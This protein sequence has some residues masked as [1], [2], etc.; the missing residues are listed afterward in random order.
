MERKAGGRRG[1][2]EGVWR[3]GVRL[4]RCAAVTGG[5]QR[6]WIGTNR[7]D[8]LWNVGVHL[9]GCPGRMDVWFLAAIKRE[10][11][12]NWWGKKHSFMSIGQVLRNC[13]MCKRFCIENPGLLLIW[14]PQ[15]TINTSLYNI[16]KRRM[17]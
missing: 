4:W 13:W 17:K 10:I 2:E 7:P 5:E 9:Q 15:T 12:E 14:K 1:G 8:S 16:G 11:L 6:K 3:G